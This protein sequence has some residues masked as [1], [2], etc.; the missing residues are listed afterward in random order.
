MIFSHGRPL[1]Q[2]QISRVDHVDE[3]NSKRVTY[4]ENVGHDGCVKTMKSIQ[5]LIEVKQLFTDVRVF[6]ISPDRISEVVQ[7]DCVLL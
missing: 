4:E 3:D 1:I 5:G 6:S 7:E 2:D